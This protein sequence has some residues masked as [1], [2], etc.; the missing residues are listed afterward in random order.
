MT[1]DMRKYARQTHVRLIAGG[2]LLLF[3]V[4]DG[5]IL[6][7]YGP[8]AAV[9]GLLCMLVGLSPIL[10]L[11]VFLVILDWVVKRANRD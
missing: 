4:G 3:V 2:L 10:L 9:T 11:S 5:L 1:Q 8:G 7:F 6:L